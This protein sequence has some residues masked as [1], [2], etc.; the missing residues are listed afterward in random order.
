MRYRPG[1]KLRST[2][3]IRQAAAALFRKR[4]FAATG[5]DAVMAA[6]KLTAGS[7]YTHFRSKQDLL[8]Q[9]LDEAFEQSRGHWPL[10]LKDLR[11]QSFVRELAS[12]YLSPAHRDARGSGCPMPALAPEID[13]IGGVPR[14]VFEKHLRGLIATVAERLES[15]DPRRAI[16]AIALCVGGL[17]LARAAKDPALSNDI[18]QASREAAADICT[19]RH[20]TPREVPSTDTPHFPG[21]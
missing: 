9:A 19:A 21:D 1:H 5:V 6:V 20:A 18:L 10:Q 17:Q 16:A 13:R 15:N 4:G 7:F 11:G 3:R 14:A 8:A 2:L 12:F